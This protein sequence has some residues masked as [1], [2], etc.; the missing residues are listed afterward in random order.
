MRHFIVV[1]NGKE[2][3]NALVRLLD[4]FEQISIVRQVDTPAWEPFDRNN[5]G[6]MSL[7][8]LQFCLDLIFGD[9]PMDMEAL[10]RVYQKTAKKPLATIDKSGSVG[11]KMRFKAPESDIAIAQKKLL[12]KLGFSQGGDGIL[13]RRPNESFKHMMFDVLKRNRV[14]VLFTIR[15]DIFRWALSMYHGDGTGR[16]GNLQFKVADGN[17]KRLMKKIHVDHK[18]FEQILSRC[19]QLHATKRGLVEEMRRAGLDA[20]PIFYEDFL[21]NRLG[22]FQGILR[23]LE[24]PMSEPQ[25]QSALERGTSLKRV[26]S[27]EISDYVEN[28]QEVVEKFSNRFIS[29]Q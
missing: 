16:T 14:V 2:G 24:I 18:K 3:T 17:Q 29:W 10:N 26:H 22:Y 15:Q 28:H 6:H 5:C 19:E 9:K 1:Y 23:Y 20:Y 13:L 27:G 7:R 21:N 11:F 4:N 8:D 12:Q 25:L